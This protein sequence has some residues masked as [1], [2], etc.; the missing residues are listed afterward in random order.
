MDQKFSQGFPT[1]GEA[2]H[3]WR[4]PGLGRL[5][6]NPVYLE[7]CICPYVTNTQLA[8]WLS[9]FFKVSPAFCDN[10]ALVFCLVH[11]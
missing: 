5:S 11:I 3:S 10:K 7:L 4:P 9:S 1:G 8:H 6:W 2:Q